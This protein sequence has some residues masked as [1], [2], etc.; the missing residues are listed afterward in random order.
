MAKRKKIDPNKKRGEREFKTFN[1]KTYSI[2]R[3]K[4]SN[5]INFYDSKKEAMKKAKFYRNY[6]LNVVVQPSRNNVKSSNLKPK[7][8]LYTKPAK[9]K[10][11]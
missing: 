3:S 7:W 11:K 6:D 1:G 4:P 10:K 2:Q 9:K 5:K 8:V